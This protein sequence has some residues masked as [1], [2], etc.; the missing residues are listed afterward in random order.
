MDLLT[1]GRA[2][3]ASVNSSI[4]W[5][6]SAT[7]SLTRPTARAV[8]GATAS[9]FLTSAEPTR[10]GAC[11]QVEATGLQV[12]AGRM[13]SGALGRARERN[14]KLRMNWPTRSNHVGS[15]PSGSR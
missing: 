7:S 2:A 12:A 5:P 11:T 13:A 6:L 10:G 3:E 15:V 4:H 14:A 8:V 1:L 9:A